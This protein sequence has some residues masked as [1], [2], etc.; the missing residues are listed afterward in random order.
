M[1]SRIFKSIF[2]STISVLI[3][4][5]LLF[6]FALNNY[7]ASLS[8]KELAN[9]AELV[10][11]GMA[12]DADN[13]LNHLDLNEDYRITWISNDGTVLFDSKVDASK[14]ENHL[15]RDEIKEA[16]L[17][18]KGESVR[19]STTIGKTTLNYAIKLKDD[20]FIRISNDRETIW[21]TLLRLMTPLLWILIVA[22]LVSYII[23][24][25]V[26]KRIV[27]PMNHLD[28]DNPLN[29]QGYDEIAPLLVRIDH[30]N[31]QIKSQMEE[32]TQKKKEFDDITSDM[33]EGLIL[34]DENGN[35]LSM[36]HSAKTLLNA[37][38]NVLGQH[39]LSISRNENFA[40]LIKTAEETGNVEKEI[41]LNSKYLHISI[42]LVETNHS[43]GYSI[44]IYDVTS[45]YETEMMR[46]EFTANVS[47]EL[48]TPLQSIMGSSE[49]LLNNMVKDKDV[50]SFNERIYK[51]S[52]R[53]LSLIDDIIRLSELD[54]DTTI[55]NSTPINLKEIAEE[56]KETLTDSAEKHHV[57]V[58]YD[59]QD[60]PINGNVRLVYEIMYNLVDNAIRYNKENGTVT[61][62]TNTLGNNSIL[63]VSD[64][65]IGIPQE[66]QN[67]I[68][69]RFYR[70]D[71]S[72]SRSTGGTGLG[73][74]IVKHAVIRCNG[75][76]TLTSTLNEGSKFTVTFPK[77]N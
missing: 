64:T 27:E 5:I 23:S 49:L 35:I 1:T 22:T 6:T 69:E 74:S 11:Q 55:S 41:E 48:K 13:Y 21:L 66:A 18:G 61:V 58:A 17:Y 8:M 75:E 16:Y 63:S 50:K 19:T 10:S 7:F 62:K 65:G 71:K 43:R 57:T 51:E 38:D 60:A 39:F 45:E 72:H 24:K 46:R 47:H 68:Y 4:S 59:L 56:V 3:A 40:E 15:E 76:I 54:E 44:L 12:F 28:L 20:S 36:N 25:R 2:L 67:R 53:L 29:N 26:S 70:V 37:N 33:K 73:L 31:K 14:L 9:E 32:L 34:I 77:A 30:Q 52:K 42:S